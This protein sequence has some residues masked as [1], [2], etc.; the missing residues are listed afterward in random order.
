[1][2]PGSSSKSARAAGAS[3]KAASKPSAGPPATKAS[4]T[5]PSST[6]NAGPNANQQP[7]TH[8]T[9][10][11]LPTVLDN[12]G[13]GDVPHAGLPQPDGTDAQQPPGQPYRDGRIRNPVPSKLKGKTTASSGRFAVMHMDIRGKE[14]PADRDLAAKRT[15]ENTAMAAQKAFESGYQPHRK[16][17]W[18][19]V[20]EEPVDPSVPFTGTTPYNHAL[21][22]LKPATSQPK[23]RQ[24]TK[25][26]PNRPLVPEEVKGE[27]AR[28]LTLLRTIQPLTVVDQ[29]C[30]ALA[31]FGGI[32]DAPPPKEG[33][34]PESAEANGSGAVFIGWVAEIFPDLDAQGRRNPRPFVA[35]AP[36]VVQSTEKRGRGR[37][38]GSK[39]S[40][41]RSDKGIKKGT[42]TTP[43]T[44][45]SGASANEAGQNN[46]GLDAEET[47]LDD[48]SGNDHEDGQGDGDDGDDTT[49]TRGRPSVPAPVSALFSI[50]KKGGGRGG[51]L[52]GTG[53]SQTWKNTPSTANHVPPSYG[54]DPAG[55]APG[56]RIGMPQATETAN[57]GDEYS[58]SALKAYNESMSNAPHPQ[59]SSFHPVNSGP[60]SKSSAPTA[61]ATPTPTVA[62]AANP[63]TAKGYGKAA[64]KKRKR[65]AKDGEATAQSVSGGMPAMP[66]LRGDVAQ[67]ADSSVP[68]ANSTAPTATAPPAPKRQRKSRAKAKKA[69]VDAPPAD[70]PV[71][72]GALQA[73]QTAANLAAST[74]AMPPSESQMYTTPTIEELEAQLEHDTQSPPLASTEFGTVQ[75]TTQAQAQSAKSQQPP[76]QPQARQFPTPNAPKLQQPQQ[77]SMNT[78]PQRAAGRPRQQYQQQPGAR[79][80]PPSMG[81]VNTASPHL[82]VQS[83]SP[84]I[85]TAS[86]AS[87]NI[88]QQR[89]SNSQ[90]PTSVTP[91]VQNQASRNPQTYY[92][93]QSAST[94][95]SYGQQPSPQ[96]ASPQPAKQQFAVPQPQQQQS[97]SNAQQP[98]QQQPNYTSQQPQYAQQKQQSYS[99][100]PQQSYSSPQQQYSSQRI[101]QQQYTTTSA[102]TTP[103]TLSAPS[104]QYGTSTTS[105]Y[106]SSDGTFRANPTAAMNFN[107]SA[108]G[109]NQASNA[110]RSNSLYSS[111]TTSS[112]ASAAQPASSYSTAAVTRRHLPTTATNHAPVQNVQSLPQNLAGFSDF[113]ALGF[114]NNIMSGLDATQGSHSNLGLNAASYN[115][116]AG[117]VAR[118][119]AGSANFGFDSGLRNDDSSYFGP[120]RR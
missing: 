66:G 41:V 72:G 13:N 106:N 36:P 3:S 93:Q 102:E 27:Q 14:M 97:Y 86:I 20:T 100:Q 60:A 81:Q 31:Y 74:A 98:A 65:V 80:S 44:S 1:M 46:S 40:K 43:L 118:P 56:A 21:Y 79:A 12:G 4:K 22:G 61:A 30:K 9:A 108:Y 11:L 69:A 77:V 33:K 113:G 6:P 114:E 58:L 5:G 50:G 8:T 96:Y 76:P 70:H 82:S 94:A 53:H 49:G 109:S 90:T 7:N 85:T 34:F 67:L 107:S 24:P 105:N 73:G 10:Q 38:R 64:T 83:A 95:S 115:M 37:P 63:T 26:Q 116:G 117:N 68:A 42:K 120:L 18:V 92:P 104:P 45:A 54:A 35:P 101:Q 111:A 103:Q 59:S 17:N 89:I 84:S 29:L 2:A 55:V 28:L 52:K 75:S 25:Q 39:A 62:T 99:S 112:Y 32:P 110:S 91:Q 48:D 87:P 119:S 51:R 78:E 57:L 88:N 16:S 47:I 15:S 19:R 71:A 23:E